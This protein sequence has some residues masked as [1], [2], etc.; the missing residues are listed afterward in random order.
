MTWQRANHGISTRTNFIRS[1]AQADEASYWTEW[2]NLSW[3]RD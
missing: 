2:Y 3:I 1:I